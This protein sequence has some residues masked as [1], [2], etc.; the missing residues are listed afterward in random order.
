MYGLELSLSLARLHLLDVVLFPEV[1]GL[2]R[3]AS[4][5]GGVNWQDCCNGLGMMSKSVALYRE[6]ELVSEIEESMGINTLFPDALLSDLSS[7]SSSS[8]SIL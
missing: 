7:S 1:C 3:L 2:L 4:E 6:D 5:L 8:T